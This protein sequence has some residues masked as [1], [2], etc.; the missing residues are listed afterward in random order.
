MHVKKGIHTFSL[1]HQSSYTEIQNLS[2][3]RLCYQ[4]S[5][6][7]YYLNS[8]YW[9]TEFKDIGVEI[10][11][12]QS[13]V[14]TS[15]IK[16]IVNP[17]SLLAGAY[18]PTTLFADP[19]RIPDIKKRLRKML[20][21][22][23]IDHRLK[24]FKL[25][26]VDLTEDWYCDSGDEVMMRLG[27][28][29]KTYYK[30]P[31]KEIPFKSYDEN[32]ERLKGA[33]EHSWTISCNSCAFSVY[34][35]TYELEKRHGILIKDGILR[36]ELRLERARIRKLTRCKDWM[37]QL[38]ELLSRQDGVMGVFLHRLY[39]DFEELLPLDAVL[40]RIGSS[41]FHEKTKKQM[42]KLV[43]KTSDCESLA[44][45]RKRLRMKHKELIKLLSKFR[46][47]NVNPIVNPDRRV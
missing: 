46:K 15:W 40:D 9:I 44:A 16:L 28:F 31:Y 1:T 37:G 39:Q 25:S 34:D 4:K 27:I 7:K 21:E 32:E 43:K 11:L 2:V 45:A 24:T 23:G 6:D 17:S 26:R 47:I 18:C 10:H 5:H 3:N 12:Y 22:C 14:H 13:L 38:S 29:R 20:D 19:T 8:V 35:K 41:R 33:N 30:S 36:T 42:M